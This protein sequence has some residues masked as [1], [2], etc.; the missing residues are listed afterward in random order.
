[1]PNQ[2][3]PCL[4]LLSGQ[5]IA[6]HRRILLP[7]LIPLCRVNGVQVAPSDAPEPLKL[8]SPIIVES[9]QLANLILAQIKLPPNS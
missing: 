8:F 5:H 1:L 6:N 7:H 3:R 9:A 2:L 4:L